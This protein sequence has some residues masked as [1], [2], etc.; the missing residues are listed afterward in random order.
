MPSFLKRL[1][2]GKELSNPYVNPYHPSH[3]SKPS[4]SLPESS[5]TPYPTYPQ[6]SEHFPS[7][8]ANQSVDFNI[9]PTSLTLSTRV[10]PPSDMRM[11]SEE[12]LAE[13]RRLAGR[14]PTTGRPV[15]PHQFISYGAR[16]GKSISTVSHENRQPEAQRVPSR[17]YTGRASKNPYVNGGDA[18]MGRPVRMRESGRAN[19]ADIPLPERNNQSNGARERISEGTGRMAYDTLSP[20]ERTRRE[21]EAIARVSVQGQEFY[22]PTQPMVREFYGGT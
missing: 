18:A 19:H 21:E 15:P 7:Y 6:P 2:Y 10:H 9:H 22:A 12:S 14:D 20:E 5:V 11:E 4:G 3:K 8:P 13:A 16:S 1:I 17:L